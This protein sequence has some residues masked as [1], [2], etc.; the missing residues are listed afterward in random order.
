MLSNER[1]WLS[2]A[3]KKVSTFLTLMDLISVSLV[4]IKQEIFSSLM[5]FS[6]TRMSMIMMRGML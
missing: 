1:I 3:L 6:F 4:K 5:I 2:V